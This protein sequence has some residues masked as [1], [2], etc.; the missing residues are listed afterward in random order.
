[1]RLKDIFK[2]KAKLDTHQLFNWVIVSHSWFVHDQGFRRKFVDNVTEY[3]IDLL[4]Q[5]FKSEQESTWNKVD[6]TYIRLN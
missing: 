6:V 1:M 3:E 4:A 5:K 2:T